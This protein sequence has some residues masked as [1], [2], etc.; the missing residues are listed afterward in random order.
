MND[1]KQ[2]CLI[3]SGGKFA[4]IDICGMGACY[5]ISCD[6]GL[7]HADRY[8]IRVDIVVGDYDS[9]SGKNREKIEQNKV[10]YISYPKEKDDTDTLIAV[11][12]ALEHG[13]RNIDIVCAFGGR[14]DHSFA[15]IQTAYYAARAGAVVR[16]PDENEEIYVFSNTGIELERRENSMLSVFSLSERSAGV[17]IKGTK[18]ELS[19]AV[20]TSDYPL[21]VSNEFK[22]EK[23]AVSVGNGSLMV[24][25]SLKSS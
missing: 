24:I 20:L 13:Y 23:A 7:D 21:G 16:M 12:H 1:I 2:S 8:G 14:M 15:N 22:D 19:D 5:V 10:K 11:K 17:N 4:D 18:Y 9:I 6:S 3:I 25:I